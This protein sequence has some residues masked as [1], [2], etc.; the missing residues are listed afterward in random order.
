M[1]ALVQ[2]KTLMYLALSMTILF[3]AGEACGLLVN[4][5][6]SA[7]VLLRGPNSQRHVSRSAWPCR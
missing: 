6:L 2:Y 7:V 5:E 1:I 3:V 4:L